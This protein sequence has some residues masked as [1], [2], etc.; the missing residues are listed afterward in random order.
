MRAFLHLLSVAA[1]I[2]LAV[3]AYREG[4]ETRATE[5]AV[6]ALHNDIART[7]EDLGVLRAEWAYLN[8]PD[9]LAGLA[10]MNFERLQ[11]VPLT[12]ERFGLIDEV[13]YPPEATL[14][15][16]LD[17]TG[18]GFSAIGPLAHRS[19]PAPDVAGLSLP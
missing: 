18:K 14:W 16:R 17:P 4:Y 10:S 8:R 12:A 1:V 13:A 9:R 5:R 6:D 11:L 3:W 19:L 15:A 7:R 2:A